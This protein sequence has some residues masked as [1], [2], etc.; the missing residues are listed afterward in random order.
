VKTLYDAKLDPELEEGL[1]AKGFGH[2]LD[3]EPER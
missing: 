3:D 1:R 2:L